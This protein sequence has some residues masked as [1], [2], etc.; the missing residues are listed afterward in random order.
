M[1]LLNNFINIAYA[2]TGGGVIGGGGAPPNEWLAYA[3]YAYPFAISVG[4]ILAVIMLI[5][6]GLQMMTASEGMRS[7]AKEKIQNALIG[8]FLLL[9][10]Y[11]ILRTINPALL[12][13]RIDTSS[14]QTSGTSSGIDANGDGVPDGDPS[15]HEPAE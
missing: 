13:L 6:A 15:S 1:H 5:I 2:Q 14:L 9:G 4:A 8:L 11:L 7:A 3:S 12:N 10:I